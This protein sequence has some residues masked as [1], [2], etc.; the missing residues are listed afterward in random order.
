M[1]RNIDK[2]TSYNFE[3]F[4]NLKSKNAAKVMLNFSREYV[5]NERLCQIEIPHTNEGFMENY[6]DK[7]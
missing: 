6:C 5:Q 2:K 7:Y 1:K 3:E 4:N